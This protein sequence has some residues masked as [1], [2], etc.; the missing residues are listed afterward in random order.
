MSALSF[1]CPV[2]EVRRRGKVSLPSQTNQ[3]DMP[4]SK[5]LKERTRDVH[6]S[7]DTL[8]QAKMALAFADKKVWGALLQSFGLVYAAIEESLEANKE[9][10]LLQQ[11]HNTFFTKLQRKDAFMQDINFFL[12]SATFGEPCDAVQEYTSR[13]KQVAKE[14]PVLLIAYAQT[15]YMALLSGGQILR[16][17]QSTAM[18]LK[19]EEGGKIFH[20]LEIPTIQ[21]ATFK[22]NLARELDSLNIDVETK[23]RLILEKRSLFPRND[24]IVKAVV[25][26]VPWTSYFS[27]CWTF[28]HYILV[29]ICAV[30]VLICFAAM[31]GTVSLSTDNDSTWDGDMSN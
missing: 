8:I 28:L 24:A 15:M 31:D 11:L 27:L 17:I 2:G 10:P 13:I 12:G 9:H 22:K 26:H 7:S 25:S 5:S 6:A 30:A 19:Q 21:Q 16:R 23:E 18:G 20:F 3:Q 1:L 14:D 29:A 4:F